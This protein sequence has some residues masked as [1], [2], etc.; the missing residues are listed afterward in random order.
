MA[1]ETFESFIKRDRDR[2]HAQREAIF[3][4]QHELESQLEAVNRELAAIDAYE[5]AKT[6]KPVKSARPMAI[7]RTRTRLVSKG[8]GSSK[9]D[10]LLKVIQESEGLSRGEILEK[11]GLKGN[12]S[13][14]M[15]VSNALTALTK[16]NQVARR[17]RKYVAA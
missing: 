16:G 4:Q 15:S 12:K 10:Q 6:G 17:D 8:R 2:L 3:T 9:R 5:A 14:E 1:E 13:G 7:G 11:M